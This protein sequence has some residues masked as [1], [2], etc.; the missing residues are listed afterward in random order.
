MRIDLHTHSTASDGTLSPVELMTAAGEAGVA[1]R[2]GGGRAT[3]DGGGGGRCAAGARR[4]GLWR[5]PGGAWPGGWWGVHPPI[6][7]HLLGYLFDPDN[8]AL[9][10]EL[11]LVRDDRVRRARA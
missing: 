4:A 10:T 2:E 6:P 11:A 3:P 5:G 7:L 9:R 1:G 8:P